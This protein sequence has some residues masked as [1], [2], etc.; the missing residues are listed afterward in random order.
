ML[1]SRWWRAMVNITTAIAAIVTM[2]VDCHRSACLPF[3]RSCLG[4]CRL[5]AINPTM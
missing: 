4:K 1:G 2:V 3:Q 5:R